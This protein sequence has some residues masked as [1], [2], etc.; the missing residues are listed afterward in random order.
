MTLTH[1]K[2]TTPVKNAVQVYRPEF[3]SMTDQQI[4]KEISKK[5]QAKE[6]LYSKNIA[7]VYIKK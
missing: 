2:W 5:Y 7:T 3:R 6:I 4:I 1:I